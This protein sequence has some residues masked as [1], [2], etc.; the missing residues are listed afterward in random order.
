MTSSL[1][2]K[3]TTDRDGISVGDNLTTKWEPWGGLIDL[4]KV[5]KGSRSYPMVLWATDAE[6]ILHPIPMQPEVMA[7]TPRP[8][9]NKCPEQ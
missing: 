9:V 7:R 2:T 4:F 1:P 6:G 8:A 3:I 5:Y